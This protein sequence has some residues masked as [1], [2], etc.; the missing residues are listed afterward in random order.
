MSTK[1]NCGSDIHA[2]NPPLPLEWQIRNDPGRGKFFSVKFVIGTVWVT[3][4]CLNNTIMQINTDRS[5]LRMLDDKCAICDTRW[6]K[7]M[8]V[9][10]CHF[11]ENKLQKLRTV[12]GTFVIKLACTGIVHYGAIKA[13]MKLLFFFLIKLYAC[14]V[15]MLC[16]SY[17]DSCFW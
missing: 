4:N 12:N 14:I 11:F 10:M 6:S 3:T 13:S 2:K 5:N 16:L 1:M 8:T 9:Q 17:L 15:N 7:F